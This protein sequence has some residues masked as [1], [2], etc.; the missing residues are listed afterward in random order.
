M[1]L[2]I[3]GKLIK[4]VDQEKKISREE[5]VLAAISIIILVLM[6]LWIYIDSPHS[7]AEIIQ[8]DLLRQGYN[9]EHIENITF[10]KAGND[11]IYKQ[12]YKSSEPILIN[13]E[14][15]MYWEIGYP[16]RYFP[17]YYVTPISDEAF[18]RKNN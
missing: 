15:I 17:I 8:Q 6:I 2:Y 10:E 12:T 1:A 18:E 4:E 3:N 14:L 5:S 7:T 9:Y 13:G 11:T 16:T